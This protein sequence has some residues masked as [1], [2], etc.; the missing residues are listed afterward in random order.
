M[1]SWERALK[2]LHLRMFFYKTTIILLFMVRASGEKAIS[3]NQ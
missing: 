3:R 2:V 1:T